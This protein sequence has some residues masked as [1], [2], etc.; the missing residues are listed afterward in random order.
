MKLHVRHHTEY[1]YQSPVPYGLQQLR[2]TPSSSRVQR[3]LDWSTEVQGGSHQLAYDDHHDNRVSLVGLEP[4]SQTIEI[5]NEGVVSTEDTGGVVG[6]HTGSAPLWLFLRQTPL[7]MP[8]RRVWAL[9]EPFAES[10]T[11]A[12][13]GMVHALSANIREVV[14]Y[15]PGTS[16]TTSTA[17]CVLKMGSGVCQDHAHVLISAA[18]CLGLPARYVSGYLMMDGQVEQA[19]SHAW[20]EIHMGGLGWVGFDVS[21]GISPDERYVRVATGLDYRDAAPVSGVRFGGG[22]EGLQVRLEVQAQQ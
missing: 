2:L 9:V 10:A 22:E 8:K 19:A 6:L 15:L 13:V 12:D 18:R 20:A 11:H 14:A 16:D 17:E 4:E 7:T 1:R 5:W 3:V 21:N